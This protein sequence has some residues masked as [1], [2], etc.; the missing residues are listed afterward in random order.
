[1]PAEVLHEA[2]TNAGNKA[3]IEI[4]RIEDF[5]PKAVPRNQYGNFYTGDSY[6]VLKTEGE[7]NKLTWDI[8]FWLG[9]KTSQDEA[10]TAAILSV[11]LDDNKFNGA[12]I[13]HRETQGYESKQFLGYFEPAIRYMDGGHASGFNHVTINPGSEKRLFQIKGKRHVRV[14]QVEPS[15]ASLNKGDCFVLDVG[16]NIFVFVGEK[17]KGVEKLKA[18]TVAN[19]INDQDHNGRG[20]VEIIDPYAREGDVEN[21]FKALGSGDM[22]SVTEVSEDDEVKYTTCPKIQR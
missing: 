9:S 8:H 22:D 2:F 7:A 17:A 19:Q 12:A 3:G 16:H 20:E 5:E 11:N 1:M 21:F 6:I 4:W 14:R 18:I 13:Q 15:A 10:G